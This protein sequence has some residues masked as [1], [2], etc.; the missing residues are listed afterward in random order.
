MNKDNILI[1]IVSAFNEGIFSNTEYEMKVSE[2]VSRVL[3]YG[4]YNASDCRFKVKNISGNLDMCFIYDDVNTE[5]VND[6]INVDDARGT[7]VMV[8][9][10]VNNLLN[11]LRRVKPNQYHLFCYKIY[12]GSNNFLGYAKKYE[13]KDCKVIIQQEDFDRKLPKNRAYQLPSNKEYIFD[14]SDIFECIVDMVKP[15]AP[16][17]S[18]VAR[19]YHMAPTI[20]ALYSHKIT[21]GGP[22]YDDYSNNSIV[23]MVNNYDLLDLLDGKIL[24]A[25]W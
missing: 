17:G 13:V 20:M 6:V 18:I 7:R 16:S 3:S 8:V 21:I 19:I 22:S 9:I 24:E 23:D 4:G 12:D 2:M 11:K 5:K 1:K 10:F 15:S 25:E 14:L